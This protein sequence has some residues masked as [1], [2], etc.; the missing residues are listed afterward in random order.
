MRILVLEYSSD[1]DDDDDDDH[2]V[3]DDDVGDGQLP[4]GSTV[5]TRC[6]RSGDQAGV[7][8]TWA[9]SL[10]GL[11]LVCTWSTPGP[12]GLHPPIDPHVSCASSGN[13]MHL[14][15]QPPF[16]EFGFRKCTFR[17]QAQTQ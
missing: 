6:R 13:H 14:N 12:P 5:Q 9:Y 11:H 8:P 7:G 10:L 15:L 17:F 3:C 4:W 16:C 2:S 1:D